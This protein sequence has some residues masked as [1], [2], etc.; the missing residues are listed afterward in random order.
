V[1]AYSVGK[2]VTAV[3]GAGSATTDAATSAASSYPPYYE[4]VWVI[5][6]K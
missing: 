3:I 1:G 5:R 4:V 6:I 2:I